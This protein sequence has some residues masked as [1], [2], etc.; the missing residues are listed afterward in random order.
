MDSLPLAGLCQ[1]FVLSTS[2]L[3]QGLTWARQKIQTRQKTW[4][5]QK[6]QTRPDPPILGMP[7]NCYRFLKAVHEDEF[8]PQDSIA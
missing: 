3:M 6:I 4:D 1:Q 7:L 8:H 5:R 2:R